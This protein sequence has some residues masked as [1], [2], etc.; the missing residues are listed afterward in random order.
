[1]SRS[2]LFAGVPEN[3][4]VRDLVQVEVGY[5]QSVTVDVGCRRHGLGDQRVKEQLLAHAVQGRTR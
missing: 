3:E 1:M 4:L 2:V 5:G